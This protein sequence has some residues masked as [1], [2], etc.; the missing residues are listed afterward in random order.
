MKKQELIEKLIEQEQ[1]PPVIQA[2]LN[3]DAQLAT[4]LLSSGEATLE[5]ADAHGRTLMDYVN[6]MGLWGLLAKAI[7]TLPAAFEGICITEQENLVAWMCDDRD[8]IPELV[9]LL[10]WDELAWLALRGDV[11]S[12]SALEALRSSGDLYGPLTQ[13]LR[14]GRWKATPSMVSYLEKEEVLEVAG[15]SRSEEIFTAQYGGD[16]K[17]LDPQKVDGFV[18][19]VDDVFDGYLSLEGEPFVVARESVGHGRFVLFGDFG[20]SPGDPLILLGAHHY[21]SPEPTAYAW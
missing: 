19:T 1:L 12:N 9:Q 21:D 15:F 6:G 4:D 16:V 10:P 14:N 3:D 17:I 18:G 7:R 2:A 11:E 5:D 8:V 13:A 20:V